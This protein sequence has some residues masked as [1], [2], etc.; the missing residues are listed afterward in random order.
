[1]KGAN[2][3]FERISGVASS[4]ENAGSH[5]YKFTVL[6]RP[7]CTSLAFLDWIVYSAVIQSTTVFRKRF[8]SLLGSVYYIPAAHWNIKL[9]MKHCCS[10]SLIENQDSKP[11]RRPILRLPERADGFTGRQC[12][13]VGD[14]SL[15]IDRFGGWTR[16]AEAVWNR[17]HTVVVHHEADIPAISTVGERHLGSPAGLL[18]RLPSEMFHFQ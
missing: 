15:P 3:T 4:N 18:V 5:W 11:F 12:I 1:M 14:Y 7:T 8:T 10:L 17:E 9:P 13:R 16:Q 6:L 2:G